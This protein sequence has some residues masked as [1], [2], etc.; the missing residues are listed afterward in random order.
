MRF[1]QGKT[2]KG[3]KEMKDNMSKS[4]IKRLKKLFIRYVKG[5]VKSKDLDED[6]LSFFKLAK[7]FLPS[8]TTYVSRKSKS[9]DSS[10]LVSLSDV[11]VPDEK[12]TALDEILSKEEG[13]QK[14]DDIHNIKLELTKDDKLI[15]A[16]QI[17]ARKELAPFSYRSEFGMIKSGVKSDSPIVKKLGMS[18]YKFNQMQDA[19]DLIIRKYIENNENKTL[20]DHKGRTDN[21]SKE[22]YIKLFC[23]LYDGRIRKNNLLGNKKFI[24]LLIGHKQRI[25]Q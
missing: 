23:K 21:L 2:L 22:N 15:G 25:S 8:K 17:A 7:K 10:M 19:G 12:G 4:E 13:L 14:Q 5:E 6:Q 24:T 16:L 9:P 3:K 20:L 18:R 1:S 11:D